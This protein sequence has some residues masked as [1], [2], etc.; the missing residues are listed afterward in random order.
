MSG[1]HSITLLTF[2]GV[3]VLNG[4]SGCSVSAPMSWFFTP[5]FLKI[6]VEVKASGLPRVLKIWLGQAPCKLLWL[7]HI[8]FF[9]SV[10]FQNVMTLSQ[11]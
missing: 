10:K 1:D 4:F 7:K 5:H 2:F 3:E 8:P 11:I 9:V 6:V